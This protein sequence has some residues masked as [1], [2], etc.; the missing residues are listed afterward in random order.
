MKTEKTFVNGYASPEITTLR[1]ETEYG[2]AVSD[3]TGRD[4]ED[5]GDLI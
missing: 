3:D 2:F 4:Y 1:I 5:G